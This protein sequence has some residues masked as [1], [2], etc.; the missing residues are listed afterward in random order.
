MSS[1]RRIR[2]ANKTRKR[3]R[4]QAQ[5]NTREAQR[6][7]RNAMEQQARQELSNLQ[8]DAQDL[9]QRQQDLA[10][11]ECSRTG[12]RR[13]SKNRTV[14]Q[15]PSSPGS[16]SRSSRNR[17][18]SLGQPEQI[19]P[20]KAATVWSASRNS[21]RNKPESGQPQQS[22]QPQSAAQS[23]ESK[24]KAS[25]RAW[26]LA[27]RK[28]A[29]VGIAK[30]G[31]QASQQSGQ[32]KG[33][34]SCRRIRQQSGEL[35]R[36]ADAR[37]IGNQQRDLASDLKDINERAKNLAEK[38]NEQ[39]LGG[40]KE[41]DN[42]QKQSG[43][44]SAAGESAQKAQE[45]MNSA[46]ADEAKREAQNA[47]KAMQKLAST[48]QDAKQKTE[49]AD[50]KALGSAMKKAQN[51]AHEQSDISKGLD[52]K[53]QST[54]QLGARQDQVGD[55]AKELAETASPHFEAFQHAQGTSNDV[56]PL[57]IWNRPPNSRTKAASQM[58]Q[59]NAPAAKAATAQ[60][61]EVAQPGAHRHGTRRGQDVG[62]QG[63]RREES[64]QVG[65]RKSGEG[66]RGYDSR[67]V[68]DEKAANRTAVRSLRKTRSA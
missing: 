1:N 32:P 23:G 18:S 9:A 8:K 53:N 55:A 50:M 5:Q 66:G 45:A 15:K 22:G 16:R 11:P 6:S 64:G 62:R 67:T 10:Q 14:W 61:E 13:A 49:A 27:I 33:R 12:S 68:P 63:A 51:L 26:R 3:K 48:L 36:A 19:G 59:Q 57:Y 47:A 24:V 25:S 41:L 46:K 4:S 28:A 21:P 52:D 39:N 37:A 17:R 65:A 2:R 29:A 31:E 40:A 34:T 35:S 44:G 43:D 60:V 38:A 7:L 42:A 30:E 56:A 54:Q 58:K 20:A